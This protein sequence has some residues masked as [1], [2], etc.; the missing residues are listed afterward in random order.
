[1]KN[2]YP[3]QYIKDNKLSIKHN[4]LSSQFSNYKKIL[5]DIEVV[6]K[7]TDFTLGKKVDEFEK[8]IAS[9]LKVKYVVS[10]GSGTDALMLSLKALGIKENDEV[11]TTPY[12]FYATVG[13]IVSTGAIPIFVDVQDDYNIDPEKIEDAITSKTKAK[14]LRGVTKETSENLYD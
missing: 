3:S 2:F 14:Y 10:L 5:K 12:T 9:L 11:I 7:N 1:M 8:K 6:I 4:Y 13:A